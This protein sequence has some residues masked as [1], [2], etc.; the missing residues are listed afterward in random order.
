MLTVNSKSQY[1]TTLKRWGFYKYKSSSNR[2][3]RV[4]IAQ[5][6]RAEDQ[7]TGPH[8]RHHDDDLTIEGESFNSP[9]LLNFAD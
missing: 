9:L 5:G 4:S 1:E 6:G 7:Q 3:N 8:T 2:R